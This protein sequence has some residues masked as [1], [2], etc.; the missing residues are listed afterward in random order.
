MCLSVPVSFPGVNAITTHTGC[1]TRITSNDG[2]DRHC[3]LYVCMKI[4]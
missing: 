4:P 1:A 2:V 3:V